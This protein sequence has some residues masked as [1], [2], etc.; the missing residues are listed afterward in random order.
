MSAKMQAPGDCRPDVWM[1]PTE[2]TATLPCGCTLVRHFDGGEDPAFFMCDAHRTAPLGP[3]P[4]KR[5]I[6]RPWR[7]QGVRVQL[8]KLEA[9]KLFGAFDEIV[10][11]EWLHVEAMSE[12]SAWVRVGERVFDVFVEQ[13]KITVRERP[14]NDR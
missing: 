11:G 12:R 14:E 7:V 2:T 5:N 4:R 6:M 10:V 13:G 9:E 8:D 3:T 1:Q